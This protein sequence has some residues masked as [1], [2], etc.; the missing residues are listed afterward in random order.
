MELKGEKDLDKSHTIC[1]LC[2]TEVFWKHDKD[3]KPHHA[4]LPGVGR[5]TP[6]CSCCQAE[7]HQASD[8]KAST[9]LGTY[10]VNYKLF[11]L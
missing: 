6:G 7:D 8:V 10:E 11:F 1:K 5:K 2:H 9:Q 3:E 4:I